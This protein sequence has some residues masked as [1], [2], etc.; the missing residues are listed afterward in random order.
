MLMH[1]VFKFFFC[2]AVYQTAAHRIYNLCWQSCMFVEIRHVYKEHPT[3]H[4][5]GVSMNHSI[6]DYDR[7]FLECPS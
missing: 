3:M 2:A 5:F 4:C 1:S 6:M 7:V